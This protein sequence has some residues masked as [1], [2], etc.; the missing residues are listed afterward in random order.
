MIGTQC[1]Y[2]T[3]HKDSIDFEWKLGRT[4]ELDILEALRCRRV[5]PR[6]IYCPHKYPPIPKTTC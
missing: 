2:V 3:G 5:V 4:S 6:E 1:G